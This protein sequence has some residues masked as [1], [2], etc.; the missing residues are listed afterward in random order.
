MFEESCHSLRRGAYVVL[1]GRPTPSGLTA[2][3]KPTAPRERA[4]SLGQGKRQ[5]LFRAPSGA[6][7]HL[8]LTLESDQPVT[9]QLESPDHRHV[10]R[11]VFPGKAGLN[12]FDLALS[13][14]RP[15]SGPELSG[16]EALDFLSLQAGLPSQAHAL[17]VQHIRVYHR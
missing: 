6:R 17:T 15:K 3:P 5:G 10:W 9:L 13:E 14:L 2:A 1:L 4:V 16:G 12:T 7:I 8:Q 11:A